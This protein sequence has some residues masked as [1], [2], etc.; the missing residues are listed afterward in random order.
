MDKQERKIVNALRMELSDMIDKLHALHEYI[1]DFL[2]EER[3]TD[4]K[5]PNNT[6]STGK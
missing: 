4:V 6:N 5:N 2:I 1:T 3:K